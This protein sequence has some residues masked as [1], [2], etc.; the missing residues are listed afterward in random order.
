MIPPDLSADC[1]GVAELFRMSR[2]TASR[3]K[4][5]NNERRYR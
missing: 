3:E 2:G 5:Q 1:V 4:A